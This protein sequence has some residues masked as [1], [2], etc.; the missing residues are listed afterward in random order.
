M[1]LYNGTTEL[2]GYGAFEPATFVADNH[3]SDEELARVVSETPGPICL[4]GEVGSRWSKAME[5]AEDAATFNELARQLDVIQEAAFPHL[6]RVGIFGLPRTVSLTSSRWWKDAHEW[7]RGYGWQY[8]YDEE[9]GYDRY[10]IA[11]RVAM[12]CPELYLWAWRSRDEWDRVAEKSVEYARES[13]PFEVAPFISPVRPD[14]KAEGQKFFTVL[15]EG[16]VQR[17]LDVLKSLG[18]EAAWVWV[19]YYHRLVMPEIADMYLDD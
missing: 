12:A 19:P 18:V 9:R 1:R 10:A 3:P 15:D 4:N 16:E 13:N 11:N 5:P 6:A 2:E 14:P 8:L 7:N 17:Q